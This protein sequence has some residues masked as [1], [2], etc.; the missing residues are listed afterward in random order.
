MNLLTAGASR[1]AT[2][3]CRCPSGV[4]GVCLRQDSSA[5]RI[6]DSA[7]TIQR[8]EEGRSMSRIYGLTLESMDAKEI[9]ADSLKGL[10]VPI[11]TRIVFQ[12]GYDETFY[13]PYV[14][15][16][17]AADPTKISIMGCF[18]DS[19]HL[20]CYS[21]KEY[22][23][24]VKDFI[25][26]CGECI[27]WW[28]CGNE[29]NGN[30][31]GDQVV[32]KVQAAVVE[33]KAAGST[34]VLTPYLSNPAQTEPE[35]VMQTWLRKLPASIRQQT[36]Y[37]LVSF[38]DDDNLGYCPDWNQIMKDIAD[39]F[40]DAKGIGIGECGTADPV[41]KLEFLRRYYTLKPSHRRF[42]GGY[43]WWYGSD[44]FVPKSKPL[45]GEFRRILK[46]QS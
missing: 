36:H 2:P 23:N 6:A 13:R 14:E 46:A 41:K 17:R 28:E 22:R 39:V 42:M 20:K 9:M 21:V 32:E 27:D 3:S 44:D 19:Q 40:P 4:I 10:D 45:W 5:A 31:L 12:R 24:R 18:A 15:A 34:V 37:A 29:I 26:T 25:G 33:V 38:Y 8:S 43:F 16:I 35:H 7:G 11:R 30:W 1:W